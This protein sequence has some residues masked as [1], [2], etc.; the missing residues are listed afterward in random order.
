MS[1]IADVAKA[2][3]QRHELVRARVDHSAQI[4]EHVSDEMGQQLP[5]DLKAFYRERIARIGDFLAVAP[6]WSERAGWRAGMVATTALLPAR[7]VPIFSDG[8]GSFY[9]VD[10]DAGMRLPS[11][12]ST[13]RTS[14]VGPAGP[15]D[16]R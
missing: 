9:G 12:S 7:A 10:L 3:E 13:I 6:I 1:S 5:E 11:T 2:L 8:C 15:R 16:L 14:L 4:I